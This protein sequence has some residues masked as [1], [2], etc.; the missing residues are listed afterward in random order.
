MPV[1]FVRAARGAALPQLGQTAGLAVALSQLGERQLVA[2][3]TA[4]AR[5]SRLAGKEAAQAASRLDTGLLVEPAE[6]EVVDAL[7]RAAPQIEA[8]LAEDDFDRAL[9]AAAELGPP[10]DRF[11]ED[12]LVMADDIAVRASRLRLLLDVRDTLGRLGDF[13]EIPL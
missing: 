7:D 9:A 4:Y 2:L 1:E 10:L 8:A 3:H 6:R 13:A 12:V 5:A 11:F